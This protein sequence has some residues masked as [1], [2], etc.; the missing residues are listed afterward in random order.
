MSFKELE[1]IT[2]KFSAPQYG[3]SIFG[4]VYEVSII[5]TK[6]HV[7]SIKYYSWINLNPILIW[8]S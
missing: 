1:D 8:L 3:E 7:V 4:A 2:N 6:F 5:N